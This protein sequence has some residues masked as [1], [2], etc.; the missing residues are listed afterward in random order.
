[1]EPGDVGQAKAGAESV[2]VMLTGQS[3][4]GLEVLGTN[5]NDLHS[6][7]FPPTSCA[8]IVQVRQQSKYRDPSSLFYALRVDL[9]S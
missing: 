2:A 1:M 4:S 7:Y 8:I 3:V 5:D 6:S 9:S